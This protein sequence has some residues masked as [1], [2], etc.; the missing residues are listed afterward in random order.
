M[1][2]SCCPLYQ[3]GK[4][5]DTCGKLPDNR[6]LSIISYQSPVVQAIIQRWPAHLRRMKK[7]Q[8]RFGARIRNRGLLSC[9]SPTVANP[10]PLP[11]PKPEPDPDPRRN[12]FWMYI[13]LL[14]ISMPKPGQEGRALRMLI[15]GVA[16]LVIFIAVGLM[17]I[18]HLW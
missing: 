4:T 6:Q 12:L 3:L 10:D 13:S 8:R 14:G 11:P 5:E 17:T 1:L 2:P 18:F 7:V 16:L 9:Y 15:I